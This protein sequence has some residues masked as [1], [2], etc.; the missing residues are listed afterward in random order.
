MKLDP[1]AKTEFKKNHIQLLLN[2]SK[3]YQ[4]I[5][6]LYDELVYVTTFILN[7]NALAEYPIRSKQYD[8]QCRHIKTTNR[9]YPDRTIN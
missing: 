9:W 8:T 3:L 4:S 7:S 2:I 6:E 5:E 1:F